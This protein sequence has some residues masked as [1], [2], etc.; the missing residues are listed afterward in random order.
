[1]CHPCRRRHPAR[2]HG[3]GDAQY[4]L[5]GDPDRQRDLVLPQSRGHGAGPRS[6]GAIA[7]NALLQARPGGA[8]RPANGRIVASNSWQAGR[9]RRFVGLIALAACWLG[10]PPTTIDN[11]DLTGAY[12]CSIEESG[13]RYPG[14]PCAIRKIDGRWMLAKL[15]GSE[16]FRGEIR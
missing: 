14:Y 12:F 9:M 7:G 5:Q 16:R 4:R 6:P 13:Y 11:R 8:N 10:K 1:A 2:E 15:A 3:P